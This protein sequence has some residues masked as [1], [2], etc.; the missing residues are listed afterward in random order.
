MEEDF[1]DLGFLEEKL[2]STSRGTL[3]KVISVGIIT[4]V[5][6]PLI[7]FLGYLAYEGYKHF[8]GPIEAASCLRDNGLY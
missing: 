7:L 2:E 3:V 8:K 1:S 5:S 4:S 6:T